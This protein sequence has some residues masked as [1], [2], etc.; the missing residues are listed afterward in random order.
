MIL[1]KAPETIRVYET[2][3]VDDGYGGGRYATAGSKYVEVQAFVLPTGFAGAGWA[4][5]T[6]AAQQGWADTA[7]VTVV[8]KMTK[9]LKDFGEWSRVEAQGQ[10][11]TV[12][13]HPRRWRTRRVDFVSALCELKGDAR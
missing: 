7:R 9:A 10:M 12:V 3:W 11:W 13:D 4:A 8:V 1:D 6:R 2:I 5:N